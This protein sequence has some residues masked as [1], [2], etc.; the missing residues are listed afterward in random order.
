VTE[1]KR[2]KIY[3]N[4]ASNVLHLEIHN[5][6]SKVMIYTI[7]GK[8]MEEIKGDQKHLD[9]S[10]YPSGMYFVSVIEP[11]DTIETFKIVKK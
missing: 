9:I 5:P 6:R 10:G 4:P 3:P 7:E 1:K 8:L 11:N 2:S